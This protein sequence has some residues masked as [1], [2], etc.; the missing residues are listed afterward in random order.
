VRHG[1]SPRAAKASAFLEERTEQI[2][3]DWGDRTILIGGPPC[4][5]YSVAGIAETCGR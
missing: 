2:R 5:A 3:S 1:L 4:Q